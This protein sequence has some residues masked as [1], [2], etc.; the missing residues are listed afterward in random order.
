MQR[1]LETFC[2]TQSKE[3]CAG[4]IQGHE[5]MLNWTFEKRG[6]WLHTW[7]LPIRQTRNNVILHG[8]DATK[9]SALLPYPVIASLSC[10]ICL[11]YMVGR[12]RLRNCLRHSQRRCRHRAGLG[13]CLRSSR[14]QL[15]CG[16]LTLCD[17]PERN[18]K[19][20]TPAW[21]VSRAT[22]QKRGRN[23]RLAVH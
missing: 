4:A 14:A 21:R 5:R 2:P 16:W 23:K 22:D 9:D 3:K 10:E 13:K 6:R 20:G 12:F 17:C 19:C 15:L 7:I 11:E 18:S 1:W 8:N